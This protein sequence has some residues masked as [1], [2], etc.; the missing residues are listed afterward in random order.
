MNKKT[1]III[2]IV[3]ILL[4][5]VV[6]IPRCTG[7]EKDTIKIGAILPLTGNFAY[8]GVSPQ[9][10]MI[11]A[12]DEINSAGGVNGHK[13]ELL[14]EDSQG[15]PDLALSAYHK[16][17]TMQ[18]VQYFVSSLTAPS[19][20]VK[21]KVKDTN[22]AQII[23]AM[24]DNISENTEN[25]LR[26]YPGMIEEGKSVLKAIKVLNSSRVAIM[27]LKHESYT[28]QIESVLKPGFAE[29]S[30]R[31]VSHEEYDG[32]NLT[33]LPETVQRIKRTNPDVLYISGHT[34]FM[35]PMIKAV[36]ES[37]LLESTKVITGMTLPIAIQG[38]SVDVRDIEGFYSASPTYFQDITNLGAHP[39]LQELERNMK[40]KFNSPI[41]MDAITGYVTL[42]ILAAGM[43]NGVKDP[44]DV[45]QQ[46]K[47]IKSFSNL[48]TTVTILPNGSCEWP[49]SYGQYQNG[50]LIPL[51]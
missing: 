26:I 9:Q 44:L 22:A 30:I 47:Q 13:L 27:N 20:A 2:A 15:K 31:L 36:I 45:I 6:L 40:A 34:N 5:A 46:I 50:K 19:M 16:L 28:Q 48:G 14:F 11:I 29:A 43:S 41:S 4:A 35:Y 33:S 7:G 12:A 1:I 8:Y 42:K 10:G 18:N 25:V 39:E 23:F 49:W 3:L 51:K 21:D 38:N 32:N 37:G 24:T 17:S